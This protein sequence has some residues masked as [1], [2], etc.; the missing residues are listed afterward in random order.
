MSV[1]IVN[2]FKTFHAEGNPRPVL[3]GVSCAVRPGEIVALRGANGS[4][5]T[6]LLK[7]L[8]GLIIPDSGEVSL[9]PRQAVGF[10]ADADRSFYHILTLRQ[11]LS[12][13]GALYGVSAADLARRLAVLAPIFGIESHL[14]VSAA[15]C[16][17]GIRQ[18]A[19]I[20]RALTAEPSVLLLDEATRS[21]DEESAGAISSYLRTR[22][23]SRGTS[24]IVATHDPSW[25][26]RYAD[27]SA[28]LADGLLTVDGARA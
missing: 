5:K 24:M 12:F 1:K 18:R 16:S 21:L 9:P 28:V 2:L 26:P 13:Y 7:I 10:V 11:N 15:H 22:A 6:T 23:D 25:A 3:R 19:A 4:G 27:V 14:D 8:A 20:V 17:T